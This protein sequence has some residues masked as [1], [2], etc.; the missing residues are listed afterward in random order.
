MIGL[1]GERSGGKTIVYDYLR[2][3]P[4]ILVLRFSKVLEDLLER[5]HLDPRSRRNEADI[6]D[7]LREKFGGDV[8]AKALHAEAIRSGKKFIIIDGPRKPAE[9]R[10]LRR[11]PNFRLLYITAPA[12]LRWGRAFRRAHR[13]DDRV[14]FRRF[15]AIERTLS[16]ELDITRYGRRADYKIMNTGTKRQLFA[17]VKAI[18][19]RLGYRRR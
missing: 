14:S 15:Q 8:L 2:R 12:R 9:Y 19:R 17:D 3:Q 10:Y 4:G 13:H 1:T 16:T 5:I 6:A 18:L 11:I 7:A